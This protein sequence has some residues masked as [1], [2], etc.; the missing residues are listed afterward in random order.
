MCCQKKRCLMRKP[1]TFSALAIYIACFYGP[2]FMKADAFYFYHCTG[3]CKTCMR[4]LCTA[5]SSGRKT[6]QTGS[7]A[8]GAAACQWPAPAVLIGT[9]AD[10]SSHFSLSI[11]LL[12]LSALNLANTA[13]REVCS[14]ERDAQKC[15]KRLVPSV[16]WLSVR[17]S[18][19]SL[20]PCHRAYRKHTFRY[21]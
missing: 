20:S 9:A 1:A 10:L 3:H 6:A 16:S 12:S 11:C 8:P 13:L 18:V 7:A 21:R 15:R 14:M 17:K 5:L 4:T 2:W 19:Q